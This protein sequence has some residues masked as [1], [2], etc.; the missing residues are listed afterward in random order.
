MLA[1]QGEQLSSRKAYQQAMT[2]HGEAAKNYQIAAQATSDKTAAKALL[3]QRDKQL[4]L[5][6]EVQRKLHT[7]NTSASKPVPTHTSAVARERELGTSRRSTSSMPNPSVTTQ[8]AMPPSP[9]TPLH[10][11]TSSTS[12]YNPRGKVDASMM[13]ESHYSRRSNS[14]SASQISSAVPASGDSGRTGGVEESYYLLNNDV[15][16]IA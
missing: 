5:A 12:M 6:S 7:R 8:Y 11:F 9:A 14:P 13:A 15:G 16:A 1:A 3:L 2:A 10:R 4:K